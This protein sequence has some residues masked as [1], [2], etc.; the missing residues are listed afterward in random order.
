MA[1]IE[2]EFGKE[3]LEETV[4][5]NREQ[6]GHIVAEAIQKEVVRA[7]IVMGPEIQKPLQDFLA[8]FGASI[9]ATMFQEIGKIEIDKKGEDKDG[10]G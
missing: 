3:W 2:K 8:E 9:C 10:E 4:T 5:I 6:M 1:N 7:A